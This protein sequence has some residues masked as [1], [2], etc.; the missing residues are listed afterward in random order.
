MTATTTR[1]QKTTFVATSPITGDAFTR[2]SARAYT[3]AVISFKSAESVAD[4]LRRMAAFADKQAR[5]YDII[6]DILEHAAA[7]FPTEPLHAF[8]FGKPMSSSYNTQQAGVRTQWQDV[9]YHIAGEPTPNGIE[10]RSW[11]MY[12]SRQ[13]AAAAYREYSAG[14]RADAARLR[15][16]AETAEPR[17]GAS[18]HHSAALAQK[19]VQKE[20]AIGQGQYWTEIAVVEVSK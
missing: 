19:E 6:A 20:A 4:E 16:K 18:F 15:V 8:L 2:K 13:E 1:T 5:Q 17:Q 9:L 12:Q 7:P 10:N 3:H 14:Q 11:T